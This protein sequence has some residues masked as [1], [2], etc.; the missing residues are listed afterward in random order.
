MAS[1]RNVEAM[2]VENAP[3]ADVDLVDFPDL[4]NNEG[5]LLGTQVVLP[6]LVMGALQLV[7]VQR[8]FPR[9]AH[10]DLAVHTLQEQSICE[11]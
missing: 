3:L 1:L 5:R 10:A 8:I 9:M 2:L 11:G 4:C 7:S 6:W